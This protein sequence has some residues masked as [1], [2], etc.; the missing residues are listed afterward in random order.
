MEAML[1]SGGPL[2]PGW[3]ILQNDDGVEAVKESA[4]PQ[5][6][7]AIQQHPLLADDVPVPPALEDPSLYFRYNSGELHPQPYDHACWRWTYFEDA[8]AAL[9]H[10][11]SHFRKATSS[12]DLTEKETNAATQTYHVARSNG[13]ETGLPGEAALD[14]A[15]RTLGHSLVIFA[16]ESSEDTDVTAY[17][18]PLEVFTRWGTVHQCSLHPHVCLGRMMGQWWSLR[19]RDPTHYAL[20]SPLSF[21]WKA[22]FEELIRAN[23]SFPLELDGFKILFVFVHRLLRS[24][25]LGIQ[26]LHLDSFLTDIAKSQ[27]EGADFNN[28]LPSWRSEERSRP[29]VLTL[30]WTTRALASI[31]DPEIRGLAQRVDDIFEAHS[32]VSVWRV[33]V[34]S[35]MLQYLPGGSLEPYCSASHHPLPSTGLLRKRPIKMTG[36]KSTHPLTKRLLTANTPETSEKLIRYHQLAQI[37]QETDLPARR[38]SQPEMGDVL[39]Q[40]RL[41]SEMAKHSTK[42][43]GAVARSWSLYFEED[44]QDGDS[45]IETT[46]GLEGGQWQIERTRRISAW[47]EEQ[48]AICRSRS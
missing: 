36:P 40:K 3:R 14:A 7:V 43:Q 44:D 24:G 25:E 4:S 45:Q 32:V 47:L 27:L 18:E 42:S 16:V 15:A 46:G 33:D 21:S 1:K 12:T 13:H 9:L 23:G 38:W 37:T 5:N 48:Q 20:W 26:D 39:E 2:P 11:A 10:A 29:G 19:L 31:A 17:T 41:M 35:L 22:K 6:A 28:W 34:Q 30:E 8:L